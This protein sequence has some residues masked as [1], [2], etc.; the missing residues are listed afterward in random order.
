MYVVG[1][2]TEE[3]I[4]ILQEQDW[5]VED[6]RRFGK[7]VGKEG[8]SLTLPPE[9]PKTKAVVVFV[10]AS[11]YDL[12]RDRTDDPDD[13]PLDVERCGKQLGGSGE[14]H[15]PQEVVGPGGPT[16]ATAQFEC[17]SS[18]FD[19]YPGDG[20]RLV[21]VGDQ[22]A[23]Q[24]GRAGGGPNTDLLSTCGLGRLEQGDIVE[25]TTRLVSRIVTRR[26]RI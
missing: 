16:H 24:Q 22:Q 20:L 13:R 10:D 17:V 4:K 23:Y 1:F 26:E 19:E 6:A 5:D 7:V 25:V 12:L 15:P 2:A 8:D 3:E 9:H 14:R 18:P 21:K 11:I